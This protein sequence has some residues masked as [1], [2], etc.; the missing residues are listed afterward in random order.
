MTDAAPRRFDS[1][2]QLYEHMLDLNAKMDPGRAWSTL[3]SDVQH[4]L[5]AEKPPGKPPGVGPP[6][7]QPTKRRFS[8]SKAPKRV[9]PDE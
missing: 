5:R 6:T 4:F 7:A 1:T 9:D 3:L 8:R 2:Q